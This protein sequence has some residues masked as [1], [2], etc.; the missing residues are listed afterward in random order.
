MNSRRLTR[1]LVALVAPALLLPAAT[2]TAAPPAPAVPTLE[3]VTKIYPHL[4]GGR[5][6]ATRE[7]K[8]VMPSETCK[9]GAVVKGASGRGATY[10]GPPEPDY[11]PPTGAEPAL[12]VTAE[13]FPSAK[14]A[15]RYLHA[16]VREGA[17]CPAADDED[18]RLRKIRFG[19]GDQRWGARAT[20]GPRRY[21]IRINVLFVRDGKRFVAVTSFATG[22]GRAPSVSK[23]IALARLALNTLD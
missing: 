18:L 5:M 11:G 14:V 9:R 1:V 13:R 21:K 6:H 22:G 8:V 7:R 23:T 19:L 20:M 15:S 16:A 4:E 2:A 17:D 3:A 10:V 12:T